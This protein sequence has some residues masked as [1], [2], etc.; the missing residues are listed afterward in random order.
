MDAQIDYNFVYFILGLIFILSLIMF[1]FQVFKKISN[2]LKVLGS[3]SCGVLFFIIG[4]FTPLS[5]LELAH[6]TSVISKNQYIGD[7]YLVSLIISPIFAS[8][9][10]YFTVKLYNT[11]TQLNDRKKLF[12]LL[13]IELILLMIIIGSYSI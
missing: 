12:K 9:I 11:S 10:C 13:F 5:L 7:G 6:S 3:V 2:D 4:Y 8:A 1:A